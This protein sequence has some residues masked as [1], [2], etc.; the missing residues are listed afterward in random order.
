MEKYKNFV[1]E[2]GV[3]I[4]NNAI[5]NKKPM[6][7]DTIDGNTKQVG[8][9]I[10]AQTDFPDENNYNWNKQ[11]IDLWVNILTIVDTEF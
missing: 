9:V 2:E 6:Y 7:V 4:S 10:T 5:K 1:E 8:Y 11:Y 3:I